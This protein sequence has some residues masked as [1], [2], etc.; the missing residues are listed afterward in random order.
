MTPTDKVLGQIAAI[1]SLIENFPMNILDMMNGKVYTSAFEF[2]IDLLNACGVNTNFVIEFL[3]EKIYGIEARF[4]GGIE[5]LYNKLSTDDINIEERNEFI[6]TLENAMKGILMS[7]LSSLF[8]CSAIPILPNKVFD[9][10]SVEGFT[11]KT[12][13]AAFKYLSLGLAEDFVLP[14]QLID[15]MGILETCPTS[16]E[17][18]CLYSVEGKDYY[19]KKEK[20]FVKQQVPKEVIVP[21]GTPIQIQKQKPKY[22]NVAVGFEL[23]NDSVI[24]RTDTVLDIELRAQMTVYQDGEDTP[25]VL[26]FVINPGNN[27][28]KDVAFL[29]P[30]GPYG[31]E[32]KLTIIGSI[33]IN[34][35]KTNSFHDGKGNWVYL[36]KDYSYDLVRQWLEYGATSIETNVI[37]GEENNESELVEET[38][39]STTETTQLTFEE[40]SVAELQYVPCTYDE[41]KGNQISRV[42]SVPAVANENGAD[43]IVCYNG[44]NPNELYKTKDM[45]AFLWYVLNKGNTST[46]IEINHLMWDS[47]LS[48]GAAAFR[49]D[50]AELWNR[51]YESKKDTI[52]ADGLYENHEFKYNDTYLFEDSP[53]YPVMQLKPYLV[54]KNLLQIQIPSQRY[55]MPKYRYKVLGDREDVP[56]RSFNASMYQYNWDY[57]KNIRILHPKLLFLGLCEYLLGFTLTPSS[58]INVNFSKKL[59]DAKISS[60]IRSIIEA[61]DMEVE[62]CYMTFSNEEF[63]TML[64]EMLLSRYSATYYG[65][66]TKK[67]RTHDAESYLNSINSI[68]SNAE[69]AGN[70]TQIKKFV[71]EITTTDGT[72]GEVKYGFET[73]LDKNMLKKFIWGMVTPIAMAIFRPQVL[74]LIYFNLKLMGL[75]R[76]DSILTQ[77]LGTILNFLLTKIISLIKSIILWVKDKILELLLNLLFDALLPL[78]FKQEFILMMERIEDWINILKAAIECIP[79]YKFTLPKY[80]GSIDEVNYADIINNQNTPE[81]TALC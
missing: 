67:V 55:F 9:A 56:K 43:F 24:F 13:T 70:T 65:G 7:L 60:A 30:Y 77:D 27:E 61:D 11:G 42:G 53:F 28:S 4:Y 63:D 1:N 73:N 69:I 80:I 8:T 17:G 52:N 46:Q 81:N 18:R 68:N 59:I 41:V 58:P 57:L 21:A 66:E 6:T 75:I 71:N 50:D 45:D 34:N 32:K 22:A 31:N 39:S 23:Y 72:E 74:L 62:D 78:L 37:W 47:R 16:R 79:L 44:L 35:V 51:W 29:R 54:S 19:Y 3:L 14:L 40:V 15:P 5:E 64:E 48:A 49:R 2:I 36:S 33:T 76:I 38:V 12:D 25:V 20:V 10:P 26:D